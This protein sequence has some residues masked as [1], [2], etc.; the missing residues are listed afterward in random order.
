[1]PPP[2]DLTTGLLVGS[3]IAFLLDVVLH[4]ALGCRPA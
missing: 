2:R 3:A 4:V 1:M